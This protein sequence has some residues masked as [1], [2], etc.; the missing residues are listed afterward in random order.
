M[1]VELT[2]TAPPDWDEFVDLHPDATAY[3]RASAVAIGNAAFG[4]TTSYIAARDASGLVGVLP[5]IEQSSLVFGRFLTSLPFVTYGGMLA[6]SELAA[7]CLLKRGA[8]LAA[9]RGA[10]HLELRHRSA[11]PGIE[12]PQR[13]DKVS[14][15][16]PLP[17]DE[18]ALAKD[19]GSKLRSQIRRAEREAPT[20]R[21]GGSELV[22][23]FFSV[24]APSMHALGTPV[25]PKGFFEC[26]V[27]AMGER[28]AVVIVYVDGTPQAAAVTV[29]HGKSIEV[30][31]A[32][33]TM[34]AKRNS[35]N[36]RMYWEMMRFSIE[37][38]AAAFDFG[39]S[40]VDSGTYRFKAQ[41]GAKPQQLV[42]QY[43]LPDGAEVP[44]L[45]HSNPKYALAIR[46]WQRMPLWCANLLGPRISRNL[47]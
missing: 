15:L 40:T 33:A 23:D 20:I 19:L 22:D 32:A 16:L 39:R 27:R 5:V 8:E 45:N 6:D 13:T 30:P 43:W 2:S 4:L 11:L 29:N 37:R 3:H 46:L 25:Y 21:W 36:M 10:R 35:I 42:W 26:A 28:A 17:A 41:W 9:E 24:F 12:V 18:D 38:K 34:A 7:Q 44:V 47:P 14:M 31:W 1:R